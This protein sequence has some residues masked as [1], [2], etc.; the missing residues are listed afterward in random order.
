MLLF[1]KY[2]IGSMSGGDHVAAL[3]SFVESKLKLRALRQCTRG[4]FLWFSSRFISLFH[5]E[6]ESARLGWIFVWAISIGQELHLFLRDYSTWE[7]FGGH[8]PLFA[9]PYAIVLHAA[10]CL[11]I[12]ISHFFIFFKNILIA[13]I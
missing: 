9:N 12:L 4:I 5:F 2:L 8:R 3:I 6:Q 11:K 1:A 7:V 10:Y 13:E